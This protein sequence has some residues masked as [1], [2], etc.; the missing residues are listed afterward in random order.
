MA[1]ESLKVRLRKKYNL[2]GFFFFTEISANAFASVKFVLDAFY[3]KSKFKFFVYFSPILLALNL[4]VFAC[5]LEKN[6]E[7]ISNTTE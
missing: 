4:F 7:K 5:I 2:S 3:F 1:V 6:N